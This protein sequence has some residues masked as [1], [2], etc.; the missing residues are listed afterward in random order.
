M[1]TT[2]AHQE[3]A[4]LDVGGK[5]YLPALQTHDAGAADGTFTVRHNT[6]NIVCTFI[7]LDGLPFGYA[8]VERGRDGEPKPD[9]WFGTAFQ[10]EDGCYYMHGST[11]ATEQAFGITG[12]G[13]ADECALAGQVVRTAIH[14]RRVATA[15]RLAA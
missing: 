8:A 11:R 1:H 3:P 14:I 7:G 15:P 12:M 4:T 9:G 2:S 13:Y 6:Y 5:R 10:C